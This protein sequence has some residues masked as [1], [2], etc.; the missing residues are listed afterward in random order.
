[1]QF[2][3]IEEI[4]ELLDKTASTQERLKTILLLLEGKIS[5]LKE[6]VEDLNEISER[7]QK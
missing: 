7:I 4:Q 3:S 1:M 2:N 6:A 5:N